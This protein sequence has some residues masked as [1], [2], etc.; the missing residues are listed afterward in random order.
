MRGNSFGV[1]PA[2]LERIHRGNQISSQVQSK[3]MSMILN[4]ATFPLFGVPNAPP[5]YTSRAVTAGH[6]EQKT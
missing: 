4:I 6:S 3:K 2:E 1:C 5:S